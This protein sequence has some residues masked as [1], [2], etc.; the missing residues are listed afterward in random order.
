MLRRVLATALGNQALPGLVWGWGR[1][2]AGPEKSPGCAGPGLGGGQSTP[3]RLLGPPAAAESC[4]P[5]KG[6]PVSPR[7]AILS[8]ASA[9]GS[10]SCELGNPGL[11]SEPL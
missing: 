1:Q 2:M 9:H 5:G 11:V 4:C 8:T 6:T 10:A 7:T 3:G